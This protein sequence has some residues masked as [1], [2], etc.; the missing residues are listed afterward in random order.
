M[1]SYLNEEIVPYLFIYL[2]PSKFPFLFAVLHIRMYIPDPNFFHPGSLDMDP[3]SA[4]KNSSFLTQN[5]VSKLSEC[6]SRIRILI[7]Y[8]SQIPDPGNK[9]ALDSGSGS[10]VYR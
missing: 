2:I 8:P 1:F 3:V 7:F 9:K 5:I 4:S 10:I 6:S